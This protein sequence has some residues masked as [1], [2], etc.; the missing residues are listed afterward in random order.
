[1]TFN[2]IA[3]AA[4]R[5]AALLSG[6]VDMIYTVPPQDV[7]RLEKAPN[8][9]LWMAPELRTVFLGFDIARPELLKSD[10]KGKNPFQDKRV[11]Q[12]FY[13]AVDINAIHQRVMRNQSHSTGLMYGPGV[14]GFEE[15]QD[16]RYPYD[17]EAGKKLLAEA[18][19]PNGFGVTLDCPTDRY[20]NDEAICQA[21]TAMLAR[22]GVKVTLIAQT[23]LK[24]FAEISNPDYHT[25]FYMLGWTPN[26][27]DAWNSLFNLLGSRNGTRG[28][29]NDGGWT[30]A[31][32]DE[33]LDKAAVETDKAKRQEEINEA[34]QLAKDDVATIPLHQQVIVWA[35]RS[36]IDLVQLADNSF[37]LRYVT[38]K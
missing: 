17:T 4:T 12:A 23:R 8:I 37:P 20:V 33:L 21:V 32:F 25:S 38:V 26:T 35:T 36:T 29:F 24:Y 27:Y 6:D 22:I 15:K 2:V 18:G 30:N 9:R 1:M 10:V 7:A 5:V 19:Y 11:R 28:V 31:K 16:V 3:N 34:S 14:G 13:Q